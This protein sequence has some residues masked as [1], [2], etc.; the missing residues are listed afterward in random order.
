MAS[1]CGEHAELPTQINVA[2]IQQRPLADVINHPDLPTETAEYLKRH[3]KVHILV[4]G[5]TKAGKSTLIN[6]FFWGDEV[7]TVGEGITA[8]T[9][10][11]DYYPTERNDVS[12]W[13]FDSPGFESASKSNNWDYI[14]RIKMAIERESKSAIDLVFFCVKMTDYK[15]GDDDLKAMT[16]ITNAFGQ[17]IWRNTVVVLTFANQVRLPLRRD[18]SPKEQFDNLHRE[19]EREIR[20][21]LKRGHY[22][23]QKPSGKTPCVKE[24]I[25]EEVPV[26]PMGH[27]D[28]RS[29]VAKGKEWLSKLLSESFKRCSA[30]GAPALLR[31]NWLVYKLY[32]NQLKIGRNVLRFISTSPSALDLELQGFEDGVTYGNVSAV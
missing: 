9:S 3:N 20:E 31:A 15:I 8:Q 18:K 7:A 26:I 14:C 11:V 4:T 16:N 32:I 5:K 22:P 12:I 27:H 28:D 17:D 6:N 24:N 23:R 29:N 10:E 1:I 13:L 21:C 25:A 30:V 2:N 19:F